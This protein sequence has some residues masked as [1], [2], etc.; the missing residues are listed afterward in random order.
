MQKT[1]AVLREARPAACPDRKGLWLPRC[2]LPRVLRGEAGQPRGDLAPGAGRGR[3][4]E[5]PVAGGS[6]CTTARPRR[7]TTWLRVADQWRRQVAPPALEP[8]QRRDPDV[9]DADFLRHVRPLPPAV[10]PV[11]LP[12]AC[13]SPASNRRFIYRSNARLVIPA[14]A[15]IPAMRGGTGRVVGMPVSFG[16]SVRW[17]WSHLANGCAGLCAAAGGLAAPP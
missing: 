2:C 6:S 10:R 8:G 17:C 3:R 14:C 11:G 12:P 7:A 16:R 13:S 9:G 15:Q 1:L 5:A 4:S